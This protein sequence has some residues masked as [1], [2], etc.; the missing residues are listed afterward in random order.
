MTALTMHVALWLYLIYDTLLAQAWPEV[1]VQYPIFCVSRCI[2]AKRR[3]ERAWV[4][5]TG[6]DQ[7]LLSRDSRRA[8][9]DLPKSTAYRC[10]SPSTHDL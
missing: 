10:R 8:D 4:C 5:R 1:P 6:P 3:K 7:N 2:I 9:I